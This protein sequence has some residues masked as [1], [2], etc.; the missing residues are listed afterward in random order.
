MVMAEQFGLSVNFLDSNI[1]VHKAT[2]EEMQKIF[3]DNEEIVWFKKFLNK[4]Y[5][6]E[7]PAEDETES[8]NDL[9]FPEQILQP[10]DF[11][12]TLKN[13]R[14]VQNKIETIAT[15]NNLKVFHNQNLIYVTGNFGYFSAEIP[16]VEVIQDLSDYV[17]NFEKIEQWMKIAA[18]DGKKGGTFRQRW[19]TLINQIQKVSEFAEMVMAEQFGLS[20]KFLDSDIGVHKATFEEMQEI[21]SADGKIGFFKKLFNR[22]YDM[23]LESVTINDRKA[24]SARDCEIIIH[25]IELNEMRNRCAIYWD[26]L[27]S[28][29]LN[30]FYE[31][32]MNNPE[33]VAKNYIAPIEKYLDWYE[34]YYS[35]LLDKLNAA[36]IPADVIFERNSTD[37][38][39]DETEKIISAIKNIIPAICDIFM[40]TIEKEEYSVKINE[41]KNLLSYGKCKNNQVCK[42]ILEA[43]NNRDDNEY[44]EAYSEL[45]RMYEKYYNLADKYNLALSSFTID[46]KQVNSARDCEIIIHCIELEE[47]R[48][49]CAAYWDNL[50]AVNDV[51]KFF[52]LD[53]ENQENIALKWIPHIQKY[54]NWYQDSYQPLLNK[55]T[56]VNLPADVIFE[57]NS[58]DSDIDEIEKIFLAIENIIPAICDI[59]MAAIDAEIYSAKINETKNILSYGKH[60]NS[61]VCKNVLSAIKNGD[62]NEY[63]EAYSEL[64]RIYEKYSLQ[65]NRADLLKILEPVAPQW[66]EAI[67]NRIGIHG[68]FTVPSDIEDAWK[69]KQLCG[70]VEEITEKPFYTLQEDSLRLSKDYRRIT[71]DYAEKCSW[72]HLLRRIAGDKDMQQALQG[73]KQTIKKIG[74]GTG[75]QAPKQKAKARELMAK[76]QKA[77]PAWIMPINRALE[78]LNPKENRFDVVIIDE[79]SQSDISSLAILYMGKKLI[80]VGDDKQVSPLAVGI[81]VD[82]MSALQEMYIKDKIP[83]A[84]LYDSKTSIYDIAATTF[85][86]LMLREHFRCVPEIIGFSNELS[87]NGKIK[88]LREAGSSN[89]LPAVI[90]YRVA[91]GKREGKSKTNPNEARAIVAIMKA[92]IEQPEYAQKSFGVISLLGDE[93]GQVKL[94]SK[95]IEQ[96]IDPKEIQQRKILCGNSANFQGDERDVIFLSMVDSG[97]NSTPIRIMKFG[98]E[99]SNRKRYNVAVSRARDQIWIVNSLDTANDLKPGDIRKRLLDYANNFHS[100]EIENTEIEKQAESPFEAAVA[101]NLVDRGYHIVQK[102]KVGAYCLN[103]VAVCGKNTVAIECDGE[104]RYNG[105]SKIREG[106]ERQTIL[107]R[108]GR[109]FIRIRGSEF[110]RDTE[111]AVARII[112]E[113]SK[114]GIEPETATAINTDEK[115][116][117]LLRR[118][119]NRA[120]IIMSNDNLS[121]ENFAETVEVALNPKSIFSDKNFSTPIKLTVTEKSNSKEMTRNLYPVTVKNLPDDDIIS[122]LKNRNVAFVDNRHNKGSL[123]II[124]GEELNS[125]VQEARK[126]GFNFRFKKGG[127]NATKGKDAWWAK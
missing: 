124:G 20:I 63:F 110:Y 14:S 3:S 34:N 57:K 47:M 72:Y 96:E 17:G 19:L 30:K 48:Q 93:G 75:K 25:C 105:E 2:F 24:Q 102:W 11:S 125:T 43:I 94:I 120:A 116:S 122:F 16:K 6:I 46:G 112:S 97:E 56:A 118:V 65:N 26:K 33:N 21:F 1:D 127:G 62:N 18:I 113:L 86:P 90:N 4:K 66:A 95:L 28:A 64:N 81:D 92:C 23:A 99:D 70:I 12:L 45:M 83:N 36:G 101:K 50:L 78:S 7:L 52:E 123:W 82:K 98:M 114:F 109:K 71:A 35:A 119:K 80:I 31:L 91:D 61:Q 44:S 85:Q 117:E 87:Y 59:F 38:D 79:A 100:V 68:N 13:L 103:M 15:K 8:V 58:L 51:P 22:K 76:C 77:V 37:S 54:L 39:I 9:P 53:T 40:A 89:L 5:G 69:W 55:I 115:E 41:T 60:G 106:M 73:W 27:L 10:S 67:R 111:K 104:R 126:L 29:D 49:K 84:H 74:K 108:I 32:D 42:A 107:E 88:P 121:A